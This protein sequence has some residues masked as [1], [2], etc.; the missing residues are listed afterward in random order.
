MSGLGVFPFGQPVRK[1]EQTDRTPK[2][3]FILGVYA[4]AVHA[5]WIGPDKRIRVRALAVASEPRIFWN[6]NQIEAGTIIAQISLPGAL[7]QLSPAHPTYNGPSGKTLDEKILAPLKLT[8]D[9][10]WLCDLVPHSCLN[11][12]QRKAIERVYRPM[13]A[14]YGLPEAKVRSVPKEYAD[15]SRR[16]E[17]LA[18]LYESHAETLILLGDKPIQWFL[19]YYD[20]RWKKLADFLKAGPYGLPHEAQVGER[21]M[22]VLPLAHPRQIGQLGRSS[23][24][25]YDRHQEWLENPALRI[26]S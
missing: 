23:P 15:E 12:G 8:R 26:E 9:D 14:E 22:S 7:G 11:T 19:K 6:G 1:V 2:R 10:V 18:E 13:A 5:R 17:I 4:S 25:W 24:I 21:R 3:V 16:A 20:R